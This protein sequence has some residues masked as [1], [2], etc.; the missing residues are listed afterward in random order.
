MSLSFQYYHDL[1]FTHVANINDAESISLEELKA[2]YRKLALSKHPD[3]NKEAP[4]QKKVHDDWIKIREAYDVLSNPEKRAIYNNLGKKGVENFQQQQHQQ[5]QYQNQNQ[6]QNPFSHLFPGFHHEPD[7]VQYTHVIPLDI[8]MTGGTTM[9]KW[10]RQIICPIC[11]GHGATSIEIC[12]VC[13]GQGI[14]VIQKHLGPGMIQQMQQVCQACAGKGKKFDIKDTCNKCQGEGQISETKQ[15]EFQVQK[16][17]ATS[18]YLNIPNGGN[19]YQPNQ[20]SKAQILLELDQ[21]STG[22][23]QRLDPDSPHLIMTHK[24]TLIQ[25]LYGF[26]FRLH[27]LDKQSLWIRSHPQTTYQNH[28]NNQ[29]I[30]TSKISNMG[31]PYFNYPEKRGDLIITFEI[32]FPT[33]ESIMKHPSL[34]TELE[35]NWEFKQNNNSNNNRNQTKH[36]NDQDVTLNEPVLMTTSNQNQNPNPNPNQKF[37]FSHHQR[38]SECTT[39]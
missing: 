1:G 5:Q 22:L 23:F 14:R 31:L 9:L 39:Q 30:W 15:R 28:H 37:H 13:Q 8:I 33:K 36:E 12:K 21:K 10:K 20:F 3:K 27:T 38:P 18:V 25:A 16:G 29:R 7:P 19:E 26:A 4:D 32:E 34:R 35:S 24:I 11:D 17:Q 6:N 2:N